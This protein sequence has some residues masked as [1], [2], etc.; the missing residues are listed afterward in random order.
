VSDLCP[1]VGLQPFTEEDQRFFFGRERERR[2]IVANLFAAPLVVL[3]GA[4]GVGK[5]SVLLA[6]VVPDLRAEPRTVVVVFREWQPGDVSARLRRACVDAVIAAGVDETPPDARAPLDD[7][8]AWGCNALGGTVVV[9]LDQFEE[10]FLYHAEHGAGAQFDGELA[11]AINREDVNAAFLIALREDGLSRLDRFRARVPNLL[12]NLLR[13][14]HLDEAAARRAI[15]GPLEVYNGAEGKAAP[16]SIEDGLVSRVIAE[17]RTGRVAVGEGTGGAEHAAGAGEVE[18]P[19]LQLV[20]TRLWREERGAGSPVLRLATLERL[21]GAG[22]LVRSHLDE[23]MRELAPPE[24][25]LCAGFFDRLV[26]PS[27][28]KIAC[29]QDDLAKWADTTPAAITAVLQSLCARRILRAISDPSNPH[30]LP[31]FEIFHDVLGPGILE[32]RRRH[33]AAAAEAQIREQEERR[34]ELQRARSLRWLVGVLAGGLAVLGVVTFYAWQQRGIAEEQGALADQRRAAAVAE[35]ERARTAEAEARKAERLAGERL[36]RIVEGIELKRAVLSGDSQTIS[37]ALSSPLAT[38]RVEFSARKTALNYQSGG[39]WIYRYEVFPV[40]AA[41]GLDSI[42]V[43]TYRMDHPTFLN[44]VF[45]TG[46]AEGFVA[47]YVGWGCLTFVTA[48]IE[49]LDPEKAPAIT[50]FNMCELLDAA[51]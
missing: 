27:G 28:S 36:A 20:L 41:A 32:W 48:L 8:L 43:I 12:G 11:R 22:N 16:V 1:Y 10:Y 31:R 50:A 49:Y 15:C 33:Q 9:I 46:H 38:T 29:R 23:V 19:F 2:L 37:A 44:R 34:L 24:Q 39:K 5:S 13:L 26:T 51:G 40:R 35:S 14:K 47:S 30:E 42:A 4:S 25:S 6:G 21:G 18:A 45:S 3:Y 17:V 7:V